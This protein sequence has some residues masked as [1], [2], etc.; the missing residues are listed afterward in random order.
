MLTVPIDTTPQK[1]GYRKMAELESVRVFCKFALESVLTV[2]RIL[3]RLAR[4]ELSQTELA[5]IGLTS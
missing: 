4:R 3:Q 2:L 5:S 1:G